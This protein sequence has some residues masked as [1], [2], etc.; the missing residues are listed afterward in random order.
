MQL[1]RTLTR[2]ASLYLLHPHTR[3]NTASRHL[4]R[5]AASIDA[6]GAVLINVTAKKIVAPKGCVIYNVTDDSEEGI[7][8]EAGTACVG[9][10]DEAGAC[11]RMKALANEDQK[12]HWGVAIPGNPKSYEEI[13]NSNMTTNVVLVESKREEKHA[14]LRAAMFA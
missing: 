6:S 3:T 8:V 1:E 14:T 7:V 10:W 9:V 2:H 5:Y 13:Y 12:K 11:F 4:Y